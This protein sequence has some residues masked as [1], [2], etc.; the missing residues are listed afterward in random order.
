MRHGIAHHGP[1]FGDTLFGAGEHQWGWILVVGIVFVL[2]GTFALGT[3]L[4]ATVLSIY[5]IGIL[6]LFGGVA[7]ALQALAF[8]G[9]NNVVLHLLMS[10]LYLIAGYL[11]VENPVATSMMLT[12]LLAAALVV[13]GLV[14]TIA[15]MEHR[16]YRSWGW[17]L[18]SGLLT[19]ALGLLIALQWP[20]SGF[21]AIGMF[22][23]IDLIFHGLSYMGLGMAVRDAQ[24]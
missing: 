3:L 19:M 8:H 14:R 7:Q 15:A 21:W 13:L 11:V 1:H 10:V 20:L 9:R 4:T 16:N 18:T 22:V 23:G 24:S 12:L 2:L 5:F 6:L 17:L